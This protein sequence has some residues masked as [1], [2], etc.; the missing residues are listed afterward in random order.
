MNN[1]LKES[2]SKYKLQ[3]LLIFFCTHQIFYTLKIGTWWDEPFN[4]MA[5]KLTI[6]K[7]KFFMWNKN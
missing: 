3:I 7:V 2:I 6:A 5:A 4:H 1:K